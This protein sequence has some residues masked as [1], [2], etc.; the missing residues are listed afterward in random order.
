MSDF[1]EVYERGGLSDEEFR[2]IKSKLA[3]EV[4]GETKDNASAV[5]QG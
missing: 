2:T 3:S 4:K 5:K 1:R